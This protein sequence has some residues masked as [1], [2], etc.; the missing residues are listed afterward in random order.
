MEHLHTLSLVLNPS[1]PLE[2]T[3]SRASS[4]GPFL[5]GALME[6]VDTDYATVLHGRSF[7]PYATR[8]TLD[9]SQRITW[10]ISTLTNVAYEQLIVP[11]MSVGSITLR[12]LGK[13]FE[14]SERRLVSADTKALTD[15]IGSEGPT[16]L[17]VRFTTPT[18]FKS[19]GAYVFM[20]DVRLIF[21]NLL[22]H[23]FYVYEGSQEV[24]TETLDYL[25]QHTRIISYNLH[26]QY[27][28][29]AMGKGRKVPA[30]VGTLGLS[31]KGPQQLEGL[32]R[33]L[34]KFGEYAGVGI[35]TSMGMGGMQCL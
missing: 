7:N 1:E 12:A 14:V 28:D 17:K 32:C 33:M 9:D 13:T 15:L 19:G 35:K 22:M 2:L 29:H 4:L 5:Q 27:F 25:V 10:Q 8:C 16:K 3:R 34:L 20:P 31:V 23:Y 18:A 24:D 21:Q 26:S 30:F 6:H 11:M